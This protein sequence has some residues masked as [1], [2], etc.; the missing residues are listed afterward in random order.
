MNRRDLQIVV[1][2]LFLALAG[3][4]AARYSLREQ[5]VNAPYVV[6]NVGTVEYERIKLDEP[7][8]VT[9]KRNGK[10][11]EVRITKNSVYMHAANCENQD[12]ILQGEVTLENVE[13]RFLGPWIICL[14]NGVTVE[15]VRG[16]PN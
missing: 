3:L 11:N 14:P 9:I 13:S 2:F 6:I 16:D 10:Y 4:V 5:Y 15:L 1:V 8:T 12:C 7:Q